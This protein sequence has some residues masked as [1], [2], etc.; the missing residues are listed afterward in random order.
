MQIDGKISNG[1]LRMLNLYVVVGVGFYAL[2]SSAFL[3]SSVGL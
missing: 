1:R 3:I 2:G